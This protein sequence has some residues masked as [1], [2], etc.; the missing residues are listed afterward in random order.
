MVVTDGA[1]ELRI[2][3]RKYVGMGSEL[4]DLVGDFFMISVTSSSVVSLKDESVEVI[5]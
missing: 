2:L 4:Q 3:F 5:R 1:I